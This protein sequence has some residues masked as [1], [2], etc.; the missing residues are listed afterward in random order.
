M[1]IEAPAHWRHVV[2]ILVD[3]MRADRLGAYAGTAGTPAIDELARHGTVFTNAC[4]QA[5]STRP[6]VSSLMTGRFP[7]QHGI[8]DRVI[9]EEDGVSIVVGL[10]PSVPLLAEVLSDAGVTTAAFLG[11]NANLK[12]VFGLTRGFDEVRWR[13]T[14]D[15][16][17]LVDD[18]E[19]WLDESRSGSTFTY[20]HFMDVHHPLPIEIP[21]RLDGGVDLS[22]DAASAK[23]LIALYDEA[24]SRVDQHIGRVLAALTS[25]GLARETLVVVTADHG[26]ELTEHGALLS[27]G[28]TLYRELVRIPLILGEPGSQRRG[29]AHTSAVQLIDLFPTVLD[30]LGQPP[31]DVPGHSLLA[32][33]RDG[34]ATQRPAFSELHRRDLYAQSV[35]TSMMQLVVTYVFSK[36]EHWPA[37]DVRPG[38]RIRMKGQFVHGAGFRATKLGRSLDGVT[39]FRGRID[40]RDPAHGTASMFG[41]AFALDAQGVY[42]DLD[43]EVRPLSSISEGDH[44][45]VTLERRDGIGW[46]ATSGAARKRGGKSKIEGAVESVTREGDVLSLRVMGV[47][48]RLPLDTVIHEK[49]RDKG[50]DYAKAD[51]VHRMLAADYIDRRVELFDLTA[52]PAQT[53]NLVTERADVVQDLE[54]TLAAWTEWMVSGASASS[55]SIDI[56]AETLEQLRR[57]GYLE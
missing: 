6:S 36:R 57:M 47:E 8:V 30:A 26:E 40:A 52:D 31:G 29:S 2:L 7:S 5:P 39:K 9:R 48:L 12:P 32:Y 55:V 50:L 14:T 49:F 3:A 24:V 23:E 4:A 33:D 34:G 10:D 42:V 21:G 37:A 1:T 19:T 38:M 53:R 56:D 27:H 41:V 15:G 18:F 25:R 28:R 17:V 44:M 13:P 11:G 43:D 20:L 51:A 35:T 16:R 45:S 54:G 22:D 46:V